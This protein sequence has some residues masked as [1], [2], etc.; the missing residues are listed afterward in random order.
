MSGTDTFAKY[1]NVKNALIATCSALLMI[2]VAAVNGRDFE[3]AWE[4]LGIFL[5]LFVCYIVL[6]ANKIADQIKEYYD[7]YRSSKDD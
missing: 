3:L 6:S 7:S 5:V 1:I 2:L 4:V